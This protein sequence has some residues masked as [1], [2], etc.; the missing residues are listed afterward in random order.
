M[1]YERFSHSIGREYDE[2]KRDHVRHSS[3]VNT[4]PDRFD[5]CWIRAIRSM[6]Q[7]R[8]DSGR[9]NPMRFSRIAAAAALSLA[10]ALGAAHVVA[11]NATPVTDGGVTTFILVER[12][13][14][15]SII[16]IGESGMSP[17][18]VTVWGPDPLFDEANEVDTGALTHG[19]CLALNA[20]GDN[21]CTETI[22]F[23]NG[24]TLAIQGVQKARGAPS[25]TTIVGGSGD[26]L[27]AMGTVLV[28]ASDDFTLWTKTFEIYLPPVV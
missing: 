19:S 26:Y 9:D 2:R 1:G 6:G 3:P 7:D 17:G 22:V 8:K 18:D 16:D 21:H 23:A 25:L 27:G 24:S 28:D 15:V 11:Q 14:N 4:F 20:S 10:A 12:A 5:R 13:E